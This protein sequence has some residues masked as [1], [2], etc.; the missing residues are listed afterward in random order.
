MKLICNEIPLFP[1]YKQREVRA[2]WP[3]PCSPPFLLFSL[4]PQQAMEE[5]SRRRRPSDSRRSRPSSTRSCCHPPDPQQPRRSPQLGHHCSL[6]MPPPPR[7]DR[8]AHLH[9]GIFRYRIVFSFPWIRKRCTG[10]DAGPAER[11]VRQSFRPPR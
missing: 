4:E 9:S 7:V 5:L 2:C 10:V 3:C 1:I 6:E 8:V 11:L